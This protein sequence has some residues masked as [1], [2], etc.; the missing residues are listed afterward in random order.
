MVEVYTKAEVDSIINGIK[1]RLAADEEVIEDHEDRIVAL[2]NEEPPPDPPD[3]PSD[4]LR[5][6]GPTAG[7]TDADE[8]FDYWADW[9]P[10]N[11]TW[12]I[13]SFHGHRAYK[14][15]ADC[16]TS[17]HK[18]GMR[19]KWSGNDFPD[20]VTGHVWYYI[21]SHVAHPGWFWNIWQSERGAHNTASPMIVVNVVNKPYGSTS[22]P[23]FFDITGSNQLGITDSNGYVGR[24]NLEV[25]VGEWFK[26]GWDHKFSEGSD[27]HIKFTVNDQLLYEKTGQTERPV[28]NG[29]REIT[30]N[31]YVANSTPEVQSLFV[32]DGVLNV[33]G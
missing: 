12:V 4:A 20:H 15:T 14:L 19:L 3:P 29:E 31:N 8:E 17:E 16:S 23:M 10:G 26:L 9:P 7:V 32:R 21:P 24:G 1:E 22:G 25:P 2:E 18:A 30:F 27:G 28:G 5:S 6:F 13:G 11:A 33:P